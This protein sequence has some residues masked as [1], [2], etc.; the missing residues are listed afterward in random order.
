MKE[1]NDSS[2]DLPKPSNVML[3]YPRFSIHNY[4][5]DEKRPKS[6]ERKALESAIYRTLDTC[7]S[8]TRS[9]S[10]RA[11]IPLENPQA[12]QVQK[13]SQQARGNGSKQRDQKRHRHPSKTA[14]RPWLSTGRKVFLEI[15]SFGLSKVTGPKVHLNQLIQ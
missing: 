2:P 10:Q 11:A 13:N 14:K 15:L 6:T 1:Y 3:S 12:F 4:S 7:L 5:S 9:R 8:L